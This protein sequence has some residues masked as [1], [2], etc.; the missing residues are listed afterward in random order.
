MH[1]FNGGCH[2]IKWFDNWMIYILRKSLSHFYQKHAFAWS[3]VQIWR[4]LFAHGTHGVYFR[5]KPSVCYNRVL[6]WAHLHNSLGLAWVAWLMLAWAAVFKSVIWPRLESGIWHLHYSKHVIFLL[7]FHTTAL[8]SDS[9]WL[10]M[11]RKLC[12][13][14]LWSWAEHG[15]HPSHDAR[16]YCSIPCSAWKFLLV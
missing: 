14:L 12:S 13:F 7:Y 10:T 6:L 9:R 15:S 2:F 4:D 8:C 3:P 5:N 11:E 1:G 16:C